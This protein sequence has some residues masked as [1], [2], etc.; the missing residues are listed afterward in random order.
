MSS[1]A[2]GSFFFLKKNGLYDVEQISNSRLVTRTH[3]M[4]ERFDSALYNNKLR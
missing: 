4:D 3:T 2:V 1:C